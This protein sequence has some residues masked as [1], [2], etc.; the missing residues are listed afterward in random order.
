LIARFWL[1]GPVPQEIL[2]SLGRFGT[3]FLAELLEPLASADSAPR[4]R[5]LNGIE[6]AARGLRTDALMT[7][8]HID[9][10]VD[11]DT[12]S[13][14]DLALEARFRRKWAPPLK[15]DRDPAVLQALV[16]RLAALVTDESAPVRETAIR[17]L[18]LLRAS[19]HR[20]R[21][22]HATRHDDPATRL[23]ALRALADLT[24]AAIAPVF[25]EVARNGTPPERRVAVEA[26]GQLRV[27]EAEPLLLERLDDPD[28]EVRRAAVFAL[29]H[30][31]GEAVRAALR[32]LLHS[33][34]KALREPAARALYGGRQ[35]GKPRPPDG[36]P[37]FEWTSS[38]QI[39]D[40]VR[41]GAQPPFFVAVDAA[42][43]DLPE[44]RPYGETELTQRI[45]AV[46]L[47]YSST[48][49][50]L[51]EEGL[52]RRERGIY[53]LTEWGR[54]VWRVERFIRDRYGR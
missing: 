52:M 26:L 20:D 19:E 21:L 13:D 6:A 29:G 35:A 41:R 18:G 16:E 3:R 4:L 44:D 47:D 38:Q 46:C 11:L 22:E 40:R 14:D 27:A 31:E 45:A 23:A 7:R 49:R 8:R 25:M 30:F 1:A 10:S 36:Q 24:D 15:S 43:R 54:T 51:I 50:Y 28:T 48:R 2:Y 39:E 53:E 33:R 42:L 5:A 12:L 37:E 34:E 9:D 32:E 17:T